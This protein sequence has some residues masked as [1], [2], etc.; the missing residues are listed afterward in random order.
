[1][2]IKERAQ[3]LEK[4]V[5]VTGGKLNCLKCYWYLL[6]WKWDKNG[7]PILQTSKETLT[8]LHTRDSNTHTLHC[9]Q[10][11]EPTDALKLLGIWC[12][13][14]GSNLIQYHHL[15]TTIRHR[16][17]EIKGTRLLPKDLVMLIPVYLHV[18]LR[19]IYARTTISKKEC[20]Q[21]DVL[22]R[23]VIVSKMG[24]NRNTKKCILH[25]S[26]MYGGAHIPTSWDLQ[27]LAH[28]HLLAGHLQL[29]DLIG[30]YMLQC[31]EILYLRIGLEE[32]VC[33]HD[34]TNLFYA[35]KFCIFHTWQYLSS[36][37]ATASTPAFTPQVQR[38]HDSSIMFHAYQYASGITLEH[39]NS[40]QIHLQ[41]FFISD[42]AT[43]DRLSVDQSFTSQS[44]IADHSS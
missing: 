16:I 39:I 41:P 35:P 29:N 12:S 17:Q 25:G 26:H 10:Q 33:S 22:F 42:L 18:K 20:H 8:E 34:C 3:F 36:I 37:N 21:L 2:Q 24:V 19:Y 28:L 4:I 5:N 44:H 7:K 32:P 15:E 14:S 23:G 30:K 6:N 1:M 31:L 27:D 38:I 13:L 43:S 9:I 11:K 40:V